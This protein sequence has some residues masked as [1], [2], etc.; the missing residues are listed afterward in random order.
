MAST[1]LANNTKRGFLVVAVA[2]L[3]FC[4]VASAQIVQPIP[5][6]LINS[7]SKNVEVF[8]LGYGAGV[9]NYMCFESLKQNLSQSVGNQ[10]LSNYKA[11]I[12][13]QKTV[14]MSYFKQGFNLEVLQFNQAF[15]SNPCRFKL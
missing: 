13:Q 1:R 5:K 8:S 10:I 2:C 15:P 3:P 9:A 7:P 6:T 4:G 12:T 11:W 14:K